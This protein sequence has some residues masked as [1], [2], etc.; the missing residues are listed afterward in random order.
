MTRNG[1]WA[2]LIKA[3]LFLGFLQQLHEEWVV[4]VDHRDHKPLWLLALAHHDRQTA[5]WNVFGLL[6][7][8]DMVMKKVGKVKV[9][10]EVVVFVVPVAAKP[11]F[12]SQEY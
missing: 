7:V 6:V 3:I 5:L 11:H 9:K 10:I 12:R 1:D 8:L 2:F 4:D